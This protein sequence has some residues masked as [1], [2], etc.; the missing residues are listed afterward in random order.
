[1]A[2]LVTRSGFSLPV[3]I[4][5]LMLMGIVTKNSIMLVHVTATGAKAGLSRVDAVVEGARKR[6]RPILMTTLAMAAGM[7]PSAYA[8]GVGGEFRAPVAVAVIGGL[9]SSTVL[10]LVVVPAFYTIM[11]DL[12]RWTIRAF[13]WTFRPNQPDADCLHGDQSP[14]RSIESDEAARAWA[15]PAGSLHASATMGNDP[16]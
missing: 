4:G 2:L 7:V 12:S 14:T 11:D 5:L 16:H 6:A 15:P 8:V 3:V 9:L 13:T 1:M 10:S